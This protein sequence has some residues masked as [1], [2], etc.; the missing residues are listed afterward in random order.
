LSYLAIWHIPEGAVHFSSFTSES[1]FHAEI[2]CGGREES[3]KGMKIWYF[4]ANEN[5]QAKNA[6]EHIS[7]GSAEKSFKK[8]GISNS[9]D[10][11]EDD[12]FW[13]SVM[14]TM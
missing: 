6:W 14:T 7:P 8:C 12:F 13:Y 4:T 10:E 1:Q 9:L 3:T 11:S 2:L 5:L